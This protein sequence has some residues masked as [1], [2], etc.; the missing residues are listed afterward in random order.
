MQ[1]L[2]ALYPGA[3]EAGIID[4]KYTHIICQ[5]L[6]TSIRRSA[7][8][9]D[10]AKLSDL[11]LFV[12]QVI[13]DLRRGKLSPHPYAYVH[14]LGIFK[15]SRRFKEGRTLWL[16]L[17]EQDESHVSQAAYGAAIELMAY[18]NLLPLSELEQMYEEGLKRFPGTYAEYHL[19]PDAIIPDRTQ[20][21]HIVGL[22]VTLLQ[23]IITA[24]LI[25][26]DWKKA[27]LGLDTIL[28]L[29]PGQTPHRVFEL[30]ITE[31]PVSEAYSA[32][33][34]A[35]RSGVQ[36]SGG[37][38]TNLLNRLRVVM[39]QARSLAD[40]FMILRAIANALYAYQ[41]CGGGLASVHVGQYIKAFE[42]MLPE[43]APG[44]D[45]TNEEM[46]LRNS[47]AITAHEFLAGLIQ[48]G[49]SPEVHPFVSLVSLAGKLRTP[50]LL[51]LTLEDAKTAGIIFGPI[52]RRTL[53]TAAG[54]IKDRNLIKALWS[55][56]VSNAENEGTQISY[57][58]WITF[59]KACRRAGFEQHFELQ[60][61]EQAH[62]ITATIE[63]RVRLEATNPEPEKAKLSVELMTSEQLNSE[64]SALRAQMDNIRAVL[65][66]GQPLSF[67]KSPFYMH[68]DPKQPSLGTEED[69]HAVYDEFTTDP[70]QPP[71][72]KDSTEKATPAAL[73][74]T[75]IPLDELRFRN[76]VNVLEMTSAASAYEALRQVVVDKAIAQR[77]LVKDVPEALLLR[78][79]IKPAQTRVE[80]R[81][82]IKELRTPDQT[83]RKIGSQV[84]EDKFKPMTHG[85]EAD[86]WQTTKIHKH[87]AKSFTLRKFESQ[88]PSDE[89]QS[90]AIDPSTSRWHTRKITK[91]HSDA[92][93]NAV[94]VKSQFMVYGDE[95]TY[96]AKE[97]PSKSEPP[98]AKASTGDSFPWTSS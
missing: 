9:K 41:Q 37:Q 75:G 27:Y 6:H 26:R 90:K 91:S 43:K 69:L 92:V 76:W 18:G 56:I 81:N 14:L 3:L 29:Y 32:Y 46:A 54:L 51:K 97:P 62:A 21:V 19:S 42:F 8:G 10:S 79:D 38:L 78:T 44:Q 86:T 61:Q 15:D 80:L 82:R 34:L 4:R 74:K 89:Q 45:F 7:A 13:S 33:L 53:L 2:M 11:L 50:D 40:R 31:R 83:F 17:V 84:K 52:E 48:S 28:R 35:C 57:N 12:E 96:A 68:I 94:D 47:V 88:S 95:A 98:V 72:A 87:I 60:L 49:L 39:T 30:F 64:I 71:A 58:D 25:S 66:S 67:R 59:A 63:Q 73:S 16:W 22:P 70:H 55:L 23:G 20:P 24:R 65:M 5:A 77:K 1:Q 93:S 85:L 36:I